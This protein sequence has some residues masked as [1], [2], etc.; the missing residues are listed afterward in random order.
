MTDTHAL[1]GLPSSVTDL[2]LDLTSVAA[3]VMTAASVI[4]FTAD[5]APCSETAE[6]V[7]ELWE[8]LTGLSGAAALDAARQ[9]TRHPLPVTAAVVPF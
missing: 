3:N 5:G 9:I 4:A 6:A 2:T 1:T 8:C 7:L